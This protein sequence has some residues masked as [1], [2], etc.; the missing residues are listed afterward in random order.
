MQIKKI[1]KLKET[2]ITIL[3][4]ILP[5]SSS[6]C[7][8]M[9]LPAYSSIA[10]SFHIGEG[11]VNL[12]MSIYLFGLS[13]GQLI[14]GPCADK[15][16]RKI[17]LLVGLSFFAIASL[18]CMVSPNFD[19]FL[20]ARLMQALSAC[21][22]IVICRTI[23]TDSYHPE[24]RTAVL[25]LISA[26]NIFS[27]ALAPL[28]GGAIIKAAG[29][30]FIF[31]AITI[32]ATVMLFGGLLLL[33]ETLLNADHNALRFSRFWEN[34]K[35]VSINRIYSGYVLCLGFLCAM[36][37]VWVTF[38][39]GILIDHFGVK[40]EDF[41]FY[42]LIPCIAS[43]SGAIFTAS[44]S[45]GF[46]ARKMIRFGLLLM[47]AAILCLT[48]FEHINLISSPVMI[49]VFISIVFFAAGLISPL[50]VSHALAQFVD[51]GGFA[52]GILG[53]MQS[54]SVAFMGTLTSSVYSGS[55]HN[56][57]ILM[58]SAVSIAILCF[59]FASFH[60]KST[61]LTLT[62]APLPEGEESMGNS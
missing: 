44:F 45:S 41:G 27:P 61:D 32:F 21:S 28:I 49:V 33:K 19:V 29:W 11:M 60:R 15:F 16:G 4:I 17:T 54:I 58:L 35:R 42:F 22:S 3:L 53:F 50:L 14:Y 30:R 23:V 7:I 51:I 26:A 31:A 56:L 37:F 9:Y 48:I 39:P 5:I 18:L 36:V 6:L 25:A 8:D 62:P 10:G 43:T 40:P 46:I 20:V 52:S 59:M 12:S 57:P 13:V 38:A 34:L 55:E 1:Q 47:L 24:K 2:L